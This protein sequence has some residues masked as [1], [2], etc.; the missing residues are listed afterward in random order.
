[1]QP[2]QFWELGD[3]A[4]V[5]DRWA[6]AARNLAKETVLPGHWVLDVACGQGP[7]AIA[8]AGL[9]A[10]ATGLD[11]AAGLL[12]VA[13]RRADALGL[14]VQWIQSDMT[15]MPVPDDAYDRVLSAF[16]CMFAGD[17]AAMARELVRVCAPG[18]VI[19]VLAWLP[20]SPFGSLKPLFGKY[21][22]GPGGPPVEAWAVPELI[23]S[24]FAG[25]PVELTTRVDTVDVVWDDVDQAL[26]EVST[27]VP[28]I[29]AIRRVLAA[30]GRWPQAQADLRALFTSGGEQTSAGFRLPVEYLTT[31]AHHR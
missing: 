2:E 16:G 31:L 25:L 5:G 23:R 3:Y 8:A 1:M 28:A 21:L 6:D 4:T 30:S 24:T 9:G 7:A 14:G 29:V 26:D 15:A 27:M 20:E 18:G 19:G 22:G 12:T 17:P 10:N 11:F 13:R